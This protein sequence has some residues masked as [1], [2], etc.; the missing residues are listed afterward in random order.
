M[1]FRKD[2]AIGYGLPVMEKV[3]PMRTPEACDPHRH[4][5]WEK[6]CW[7]NISL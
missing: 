5:K 2:D 7:A 1:S 6:N 3:S 4:E